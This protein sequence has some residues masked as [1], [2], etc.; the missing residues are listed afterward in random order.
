LIKVRDFYSFNLYID[1][2]IYLFREKI[3]FF[4]RKKLQDIEKVK[5]RMSMRPD[6]ADINVLDMTEE[7]LNEMEN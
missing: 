6:M 7:E 1:I 2:N 5:L 4:K 3:G